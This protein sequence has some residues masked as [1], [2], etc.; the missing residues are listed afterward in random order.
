MGIDGSDRSYRVET[1][2]DG[3]VRFYNR[4]GYMIHEHCPNGS[5]CCGSGNILINNRGGNQPKPGN[6]G[7]LK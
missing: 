5:D 2:V 7:E 1:D 6:K 3:H 4:Q